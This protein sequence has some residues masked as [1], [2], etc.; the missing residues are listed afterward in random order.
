MKKISLFIAF[1]FVSII[2]NKVAAGT[3]YCIPTTAE[4][5]RVDNYLNGIKIST[6]IVYGYKVTVP[7]PPNT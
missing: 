6:T 7:P 2:G 4:C 1:F 3:T 5:E